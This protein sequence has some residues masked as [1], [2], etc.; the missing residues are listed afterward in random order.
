MEACRESDGDFVRYGGH[1]AEIQKLV[2]DIT[3]EI[4]YRRDQAGGEVA[5][6]LEDLAAYLHKKY[7]LE[8]K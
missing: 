7:I 1:L 4:R 2:W 5:E 8:A 6:Q 3:G